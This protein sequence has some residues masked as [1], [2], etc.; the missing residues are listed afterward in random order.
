MLD[1]P[2]ITLIIA[3]ILAGETAM[4]IPGTPVQQAFQPTQQGTNTQPTAFLT[5]LFDKRIG[6]QQVSDAWD[7]GTSRMIST[8]KQLY[9]TTFQASA[10]SVQNPADQTQKTASDILNLVA[11]ILQSPETI[12]AF[13]AQNMGILKISDVRN[14][15]FTD[16]RDRFEASPSLDFT[17]SHSQVLV[18]TGN[19]IDHTELNILP[20]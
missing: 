1:N 8:R 2:L 7:E 10:L 5:K 14:P 15:Y 16:D 3:L 17:I 9:E 4:G 6:G 19:P 13:Q 11:A 20:V 18:L 12:A